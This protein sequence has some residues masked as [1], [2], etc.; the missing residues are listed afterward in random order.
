MPTVVSYRVNVRVLPSLPI[1]LRQLCPS[2][3]EFFALT[4][5]WEGKHAFL[6]FAGPGWLVWGFPLLS[7]FK[8]SEDW[9][10]H[11]SYS[12]LRLGCQR[13]FYALS[14]CFGQ[15]RIVGR[16]VT[17]PSWLWRVFECSFFVVFH[18]TDAT[19]RFSYWCSIFWL[20]NR[21]LTCLQWYK[22]PFG[23]QILLPRG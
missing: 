9:L 19:E 2:G 15:V 14:Y 8:L 21:R 16:K 6:Y 10:S 18:G 13:A 23:T 11:I 22:F 17:K 12:T 3:H 1:Q 7:N 20:R 5:Q 4:H